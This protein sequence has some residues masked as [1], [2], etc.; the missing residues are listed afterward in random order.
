MA[1]RHATRPPVRTPLMALQRLVK[2]PVALHAVALAS[3][4]RIAQ[5]HERTQLGLA[6]AQ[7]CV[8]GSAPQDLRSWLTQFWGRFSPRRSAVAPP[9][10]A[11]REVALAWTWLDDDARAVALAAA[12][13]R[14]G[15]IRIDSALLQDR[16]LESLALC[17]GEARS[18]ELIAWAARAASHDDVHVRRA[19]ERSLLTLALWSVA[20]DGPASDVDG[21]AP[22]P[23]TGAPPC[24][25]DE[26]RRIAAAL[27][28]MDNVS[29][30]LRSRGAVLSVIVAM[31]RHH[32][33]E[34]RDFAR[35]LASDDPRV[36]A[37]LGA[38]RSASWAGSRERAWEWL[39][40]CDPAQSKRLLHACAARLSRART[41]AEHALVLR[42]A[43][44]ALSPRR[45]LAMGRIVVRGARRSFRQANVARVP[46]MS[47][48]PQVS[49]LRGLAMNERRELP[50]WARCIG[51]DAAMKVAACEPLLADEDPAVRMALVRHAPSQLLRDL[52]LDRHPSIACA[53]AVRAA[54]ECAERGSHVSEDRG[55]A[56]SL[57]ARRGASMH[58]RSPH[59][60]VRALAT[61]A[62]DGHDASFT[63]PQ[64]RAR[65][66]AWLRDDRAGAMAFLRTA[67][68]S[69]EDNDAIGAMQLAR[70]M[71]IAHEL[72]EQAQRI[73]AR[74]A[75]G[76]KAGPDGLRVIA[77]ATSM[78][79]ACDTDAAWPLLQHAARHS[80]PR[81]QANAI[82]ALFAQ[83]R[84]HPQRRDE[85]QTMLEE[86]GLQTRAGEHQPHRVRGSVVR[87]M[88]AL[89][90]V[91]ASMS[92][93]REDAGH[94]LE[95]MLRDSRAEHRLA[96]VW[97][98]GRVRSWMGAGALHDWLG[99]RA[100]GMPAVSRLPLWRAS[101]DEMSVTEPHEH[102]RRRAA[103]CS[104]LLGAGG[105][106]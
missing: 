103:A 96:G 33:R 26:A 105:G 88:L 29:G 28:Q 1:G 99:V 84:R 9:V 83:V 87:A 62:G 102:V 18:V 64:T 23:R 12:G 71:G 44:L 97:V 86:L 58:A 45:T 51:A 34:Q 50:R 16:Q 76:A 59:A 70:R 30:E 15:R 14:W 24:Q 53:A 74:D 42:L 2:L 49:M 5:P 68:M 39:G 63:A 20:M 82:D 37:I 90:S 48:L 55:A 19:G 52:S 38:L 4:V 56:C 17:A 6:L 21:I 77:T 98:L 80:D 10:A 36:S 11:L 104:S 69:G 43:H 106:A 89:E 78:L 47:A 94:A 22:L 8:P 95:A 31:H 79:G 25:P 13:G 3:A 27:A 32:L 61:L 7:L 92:P 91:R 66:W 54:D 93:L 85:L 57:A 40:L 60:A 100:S 41:P 81:V 46:A 101:L 72:V 75:Q 65:L 67:A 35:A 73:L